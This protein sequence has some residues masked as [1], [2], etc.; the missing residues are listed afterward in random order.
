MPVDYTKFDKVEESDDEEAQKAREE[1]KKAIVESATAKGPECGNC[2]KVCVKVL[3][4]GTC[5]AKTYC[6]PACQ[7]EDWKFHKRVCK[8]FEDKAKKER[9][10]KEKKEKEEKDKAARALAKKQTGKSE[11]VRDDDDEV[12]DWYRHREWIPEKK[13]HFVPTKVTEPQKAQELEPATGGAASAWNKAGTWED[14][15]TLSWWKERLAS[16][17]TAVSVETSLGTAT[18]TDV[19]NIKGEASIASVRGRVRY[20]FDLQMETPFVMKRMGSDGEERIKGRVT[21][22][23]FSDALAA[24]SHDYALEVKCDTPGWKD[25]G[26]RV[27]EAELVPAMK[28]ALVA[29]IA[30]YQEETL[31][32]RETSKEAAPA[33]AAAYPA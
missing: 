3:K 8:P 10:E 11:V 12:G 19:E 28:A 25:Q 5:K 26:R 33:V 29:L 30:D 1:K 18:I 24:D 7:K 32:A 22:T 20:L 17:L 21:F 13:Q 2:A 15:D 23:E 9:E 6:S 14:K 16:A 27:A 4:C 31:V